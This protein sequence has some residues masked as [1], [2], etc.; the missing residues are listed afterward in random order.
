MLTLVKSEGLIR[1]S[2]RHMGTRSHQGHKFGL[3]GDCMCV[4]QSLMS[5]HVGHRHMLY[6]RKVDT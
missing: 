4:D 6:A 3:E 1:G 2:P 5:I